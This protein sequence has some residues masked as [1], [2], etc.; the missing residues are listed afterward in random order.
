M[1]V[2]TDFVSPIVFILIFFL[3]VASGVLCG[4]C[5]FCKKPYLVF[6]IVFISFRWELLM[7]VLGVDRNDRARLGWV[8][9]LAAIFFGLMIGFTAVYFVSKVSKKVG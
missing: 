5:R 1:H 6:A 2:S 4:L 8:G 3:G 9:D 7:V